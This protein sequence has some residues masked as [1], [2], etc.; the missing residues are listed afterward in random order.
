MLV[1]PSSNGAGFGVGGRGLELHYRR[2]QRVASKV[3]AV[4]A[5][6]MAKLSLI[7]HLSKAYGGRLASLVLSIE[8]VSYTHVT[9]IVS[10]G[11]PITRSKVRVPLPV[12]TVAVG[13]YSV[14][15][16]LACRF[17][18]GHLS[19]PAGRS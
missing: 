8:L 9:T 19:S 5:V 17:Q 15:F 16:R 18:R 10:V 7:Q 6:P 1:L 11:S 13:L 2:P 14:Q 4:A 12:V 3:G